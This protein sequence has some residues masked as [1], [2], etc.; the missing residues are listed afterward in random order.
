M[1]TIEQVA[2]ELKNLNEVT[3][4]STELLLDGFSGLNSGNE[5]V[6]AELKGIREVL[7][8][9]MNHVPESIVSGFEKI[10]VTDRTERENFV[11][12]REK[13]ADRDGDSPTTP[14]K[15]D[16]SKSTFGKAFAAGREEDL[17]DMFGL[18]G[19]QQSFAS[20]LGNITQIAD[21]LGITKLITM[22]G[23]GVK[24]VFTTV[25]SLLK[26]LATNLLSF[27]KGA[28]FKLLGGIK[29][30]LTLLRVGMVGLLTGVQSAIMA[31][32]TGLGPALVAMAPFIAIGAVIAAGLAALTMGV[33]GFVDAFKGQDGDMF[34][35]ILAG[36]T[37][38]SNG[39]LKA[40][41]IP[42]DWIID[43]T[44]KVLDFFGFD[45]AAKVLEEFSLSAMV[46]SL[47]DGVLDFLLKIKDGITGFASDAWNGIKS[48]FGFGDDEEEAKAP[49]K[50]SD[51]ER[52][53]LEDV[54]DA[55]EDGTKRMVD[56]GFTQ[57][58]AEERANKGSF[59]P[60]K[61]RK[62]SRKLSTEQVTDRLN[63]DMTAKIIEQAKTPE[64]ASSV[65]EKQY[66]YD[67]TDP[68]TGE[69]I[70][71]AG[72]PEEA[73]KIAMETG[74]MLATPVE[75]EPMATPPAS[76]LNGI[77]VKPAD[78]TKV[79]R[80]RGMDL[81]TTDLS[82]KEGGKRGMDLG[83]TDTP[84]TRSLQRAPRSTST[85][86][87]APSSSPVVIGGTKENVQLSER[88]TVENNQMQNNQATAN[89][90]TSAGA[91]IL[92]QSDNSTNIQTTNVTSGGM[93]SPV[94]KSDRV[95]VRR[96]RRI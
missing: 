69:L 87:S 7:N 83:S 60:I 94:D 58:Q 62:A 2:Q 61:T 67:V 64:G 56:Q 19:L 41:T 11:V 74:G 82:V 59:D 4:I 12:N 36:L 43:L 8:N 53:V 54:R 81:G 46:D 57:E 22:V 79:S 86:I 27:G 18:K 52:K 72:T 51:S 84:S 16:K 34:D 23:V 93:S 42:L 88:M 77:D 6:V 21:K 95:S 44:A 15:P 29:K 78:P 26:G 38:F 96:G 70:D 75:V 89:N 50:L 85:V 10:I 45:G 9:F 92:T 24:S 48:F 1:S 90:S 76:E 35:K 73:N 71:S 40:L 47:T 63:E 25:G 37:G 65:K 32:V 33:M 80:K 30:G 91:T 3:D 39:L 55:R 17:G 31:V 20:K 5:L 14:D 66:R 28:Y 49:R 13:V 68:V